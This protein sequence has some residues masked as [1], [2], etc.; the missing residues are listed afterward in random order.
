M[1]LI[2]LGG[3][4]AGQVRQHEK[5]LLED[6]RWLVAE[7]FVSNDLSSEFWAM[8]AI[9]K[10]NAPTEVLARGVLSWEDAE[11]IT[12][13][14]AIEL[15]RETL[16]E[17]PFGNEPGAFVVHGPPNEPTRLHVHFPFTLRTPGKLYRRA[18]A[19]R[20]LWDA[21]V[22]VA[23]RHGLTVPHKTGERYHLR[24]AR[25]AQV[26]QTTPTLYSWIC[27]HVAPELQT[28]LETAKSWG[29]VAKTLEKYGLRYVETPRGG[30][31]LADDSRNIVVRASAVTLDLSRTRLEQRFG[32]LPS[33]ERIPNAAR[34]TTSYAHAASSADDGEIERHRAARAAWTEVYEPRITAE[35]AQLDRT[36]GER[37]QEI[38]QVEKMILAA[39][40]AGDFDQS[41]R[42]GLGEAARE[43]RSRA[44]DE[45]LEQH[46]NSMRVLY[47]K[48]PKKPSRKLREWQK[49]RF[50]KKAPVGRIIAFTAR[51]PQIPSPPWNAVPSPMGGYDLYYSR[52]RVATD[53]GQTISILDADL[54]T[55]AIETL[56][57]PGGYRVEGPA[58]LRD[59]VRQVAYSKH[60]NV[61]DGGDPEIEPAPIH[62]SLPNDPVLRRCLALMD[63]LRIRPA[64][65]GVPY[66][67][68]T[69]MPAAP[70]QI[71]L[72]DELIVVVRG[73]D[74]C[75]IG[76]GIAPAVVGEDIAIFRC[77]DAATADELRRRAQKAGLR[78]TESVPTAARL[79]FTDAAIARIDVRRPSL[80]ASIF[81]P[82]P[83]AHE[84]SRE[85]TRTR[86]LVPEQK[87]KRR[88]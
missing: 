85:R 55:E 36:Y 62:A 58:P 56:A 37:C 88:R 50:T 40:R 30:G 7:P 38:A 86:G 57:L 19:R 11:A 73:S 59:R 61:S 33:F 13:R 28:A 51:E 53:D 45:A 42:R 70:R 39:V 41:E 22:K 77:A 65:D 26:W 81:A 34:L 83:E 63:A 31:G 52:R 4:S 32:P 71:E 10:D 46:T 20:T 23:A 54:P 72:R 82:L 9:A 43:Y 6:E 66:R 14:A 21:A 78:V 84:P 80:D 48:Y 67:A 16:E 2:V 69:Q 18:E 47:G 76:S 27:E 3:L 15:A 75:A 1:M 35:R 29:D 87:K 17:T 68:E 64:L 5:Y 49:D 24:I 79:R 25:A 44:V 8:R 74:V 12:P 60:H